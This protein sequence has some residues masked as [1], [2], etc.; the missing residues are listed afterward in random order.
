MASLLCLHGSALRSLPGLV[1]VYLCTRSV[2]ATEGQTR[3][4]LC[5]LIN[6]LLKDG[7]T[8]D[9]LLPNHRCEPLRVQETAA[10]VLC[11][12]VTSGSGRTRLER[13][14]HV[15]VRRPRMVEVG[16]E[17]SHEE[18]GQVLRVLPLPPASAPL[19]LHR[20]SRWHQLIAE[21]HLLVPWSVRDTSH[22]TKHNACCRLD[23]HPTV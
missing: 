2:H 8:F 22:E 15:P 7:D 1:R 23:S 13:L 6:K 10:S 16:R 14:R 3:H 9:L 21:A 19:L 18:V 20:L 5:G 12:A 17:R 11:L 4:A